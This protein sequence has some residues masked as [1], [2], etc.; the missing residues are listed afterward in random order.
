MVKLWKLK[1]E[2]LR[3][4]KTFFFN[5]V[6]NLNI[7]QYCDFDPT[8]ENVKDPTLKAILKYEKHPSVLAIITKCN[9]NGVF[10]FREVS[11][12]Q[13]KTQISL[14]KLNKASKYSDIPT[15]IIKEKLRYIFKL[16]LREYEQ[17]QKIV[18]FSIML[19]TC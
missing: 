19:E 3:F 16:H 2:L 12:K 7:S 13:I 15:K 9:K 4:L 1:M 14:L 6:K 18:L 8:I 5:I 17:F 11:L 10:S